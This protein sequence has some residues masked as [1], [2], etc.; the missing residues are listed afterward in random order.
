MQEDFHYYATYCAAYMAGYSHE[1]SM[2][3]CYSAQFV[4][5]CTRTYLAGLRA[6]LAAATTQLQLEL[7]DAGSDQVSLQEMTR[8]WASFHFLPQDL[9]ADPGRKCPKRYKNKYRL[10]CGPNSDLIVDTVQL[11]RGKSL[12]A[13]GIAMHVLADTWAHRYFAG[14]PSLVIN[15]TNKY[16]FEYRLRDGVTEVERVR[17]NHNPTA[18]DDVEEGRYTNSISQNNEKS[19]MNLGHGRAGHLPDYS[20]IRYRYMPAWGDYRVIIKDNP[21]DYAHAFTQM[22]Y[23]LKFL[24]GEVDAFHKETYDVAAVA[25]YRDRIRGILT[26]RQLDA[27]AD[28]KAFGEEL[29]GRVIDDFDID[30]YREEYVKA[31]PVRKDD[32]F[33]GRF[34]LAAMAQKS[35]VTNRIYRSGNKLAG[36]SIDYETK[37]FRG[38][39]DYAKLIQ[40]NAEAEIN[41]SAEDMAEFIGI[42]QSIRGDDDR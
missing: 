11:A 1:E 27:C 40:K 32:T 39:R 15:D 35:M 33:I 26:R 7:A 14:T 16:F 36:Y 23:A 19:I 6:P 12:Q 22:V 2:D 3:I 25:P 42:S 9:Y 18:T 20:W 30:R 21:L 37:G 13:V 4:D 24:R 29:S 5:L 8:I 34:V 17:F 41:D 31:G 10:I 38:V 28:W